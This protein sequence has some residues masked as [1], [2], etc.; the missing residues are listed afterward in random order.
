LSCRRPREAWPPLRGYYPQHQP[1]NRD[2]PGVR[3][4]RHPP[5]TLGLQASTTP[6]PAASARRYTA[7]RPKNRPD[8]TSP[9]RPKTVYV[10]AALSPQGRRC[11]IRGQRGQGITGAE[12]LDKLRGPEAH[13]STYTALRPKTRPDYTRLPHPNSVHVRAG[14]RGR[15]R[16]GAGPG[17]GGQGPGA[18]GQG[19]GARGQGRNGDGPRRRW[20]W[21]KRARGG[22]AG[23]VG[24]G[25]WK[26]G[27]PPR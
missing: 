18:R 2:S 24:A 1:A 12:G 16:G 11:G 17:A 8:C 4:L 7:L 9:S 27:P 23:R 20:R 6:G 26:S 22:R 21:P 15:S 25:L 14:G 5:R 10:C 19:P 3:S 13:R